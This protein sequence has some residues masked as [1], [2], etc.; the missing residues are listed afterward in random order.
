MY[1]DRQSI[2]SGRDSA[3]H[4]TTGSAS[5]RTRPTKKGSVRT[6]TKQMDMHMPE[7]G[8]VGSMTIYPAFPVGTSGQPPQSLSEISADQLVTSDDV[9]LGHG[10]GKKSVK[11][12]GTKQSVKPSSGVSGMSSSKYSGIS[13]LRLP[14]LTDS[15]AHLSTATMSFGDNEGSES[16]SISIAASQ[17]F[18]DDE[19][20]T[21]ERQIVNIPVSFDDEPTPVTE[22]EL[23]RQFVITLQE[24]ESFDLFSINRVSLPANSGP[25]GEQNVNAPEMLLTSEKISQVRERN[26]EYLQKMKQM[27]SELRSDRGMVTMNNTFKHDSTRPN[28]SF[29]AALHRRLVQDRAEQSK[30]EEMNDLDPSERKKKLS[31]DLAKLYSFVDGVKEEKGTQASD[32][33][34][35]DAYKEDSA[36]EEKK[37]K[38]RELFEAAE[39]AEEDDNKSVSSTNTSVAPT[40]ANTKRGDGD[41][42]K[43]DEALE[44][45]S[46]ASGMSFRSGV[47][48]EDDT[49]SIGFGQTKDLESTAGH[50]RAT[51]NHEQG[52]GTVGN[53]DG[54]KDGKSVGKQLNRTLRDPNELSWNMLKRYPKLPGILNVIESIV[55]ETVYEQE[56]EIFRG[57]QKIPYRDGCEKSATIHNLW[58]WE[59]PH[60]L[61]RSLGPSQQPSSLIES[62][63]SKVKS[64]DKSG[65]LMEGILGALSGEKGM[66]GMSALKLLGDVEEEEDTACPITTLYSVQKLSVNTFNNDIVAAAYSPNLNLIQ[67]VMAS[68]ESSSGMVGEK[69]GQSQLTPS[70]LQQLPQGLILIWSLKNLKYPILSYTSL[71]S[72]PLSLLFSPAHPSIL[73]ASFND[74]SIAIYDIRSKQSFCSFLTYSPGCSSVS[75]LT[76]TPE[77]REGVGI[78]KKTTVSVTDGHTDGVPELICTSSLSKVGEGGKRKESGENFISIGLDGRVLEWQPKKGMERVELMKLKRI[79]PKTHQTYM[80]SL[81][82]RQAA[83]TCIDFSPADPSIYIVGTEDGNIHK[84]SRS[85]ADYVETY[86]GH[87][88]SVTKV[89]WNPFDSDYFVSSG[90]DSTIRLWHHDHPTGGPILMFSSPAVADAK[91]NDIV[92]STTTST[93]FAVAHNDGS[94]AIWDIAKSV[95]DPIASTPSDPERA[96]TSIEFHPSDP[97]VLFAGDGGGAICVFKLGNIHELRPSKRIPQ[98]QMGEHFRSSLR[99]QITGGD[100]FDSTPL[101][102][103][104]LVSLFSEKSDEMNIDDDND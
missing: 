28:F 4:G 29:T 95:V 97:N 2:A 67:S 54:K 73:A 40:E 22:Q 61:V 81:L 25:R 7:L 99:V 104:P 57:V 47:Y 93:V 10:T 46:I 31:A 16:D 34:I 102:Y 13:A 5:R 75:L 62:S 9:F 30:E 1:D 100:I 27:T 52:E 101:A 14:G 26:E 6:H 66:E 98:S 51:S 45:S 18:G 59:V 60:T 68:N 39:Q 71:P 79:N 58:K 42:G 32:H 41:D 63:T 85:Y 12:K 65:G 3:S 88:G 64:G 48:P 21:K 44:T 94:I 87:M 69:N 23:N 53:E 19:I 91:P 20:Q 92:W 77:S 33:I 55:L 74:G 96:F 103:T 49:K 83:G 82:S 89:R 80:N 84:C 43:K 8:I 56:I 24:T 90:I 86:Y 15:S 37:K 38:E 11:S 35:F 17:A 72:T 78:G 50:S 76:T 70:L 36:L